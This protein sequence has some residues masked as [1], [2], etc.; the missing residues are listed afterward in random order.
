MSSFTEI[1]FEKSPTVVTVAKH[2]SSETVSLVYFSFWRYNT[3]WSKELYWLKTTNCLTLKD[4]AQTSK[5]N[6]IGFSVRCWK[7][8]FFVQ[9]PVYYILWNSRTQTR[10][11]FLN[12]IYLLIRVHAFIQSNVQHIIHQ[13][14]TPLNMS[15]SKE[16][17]QL[18][19]D[20]NVSRANV[21]R[22]NEA[23]SNN[24]SHAHNFAWPVLIAETEATQGACDEQR[25]R[26][27]FCW[28]GAIAP[29][30]AICERQKSFTRPLIAQAAT[31]VQQTFIL[32]V[33]KKSCLQLD[34]VVESTFTRNSTKHNVP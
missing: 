13:T 10:S 3:G 15:A 5:R 29:V 12:R 14:P 11:D 30:T 27:H 21:S 20:Y 4:P 28:S 25:R 16:T 31:S 8:V 24:T 2:I 6:N 26:E 34:D 23:M 7:N 9:I 22:T 32:V 18:K 19:R 33:E 17:S 1:P